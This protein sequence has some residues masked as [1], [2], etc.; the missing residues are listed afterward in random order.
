MKKIYALLFI[1]LVTVGAIAQSWSVP[2]DNVGLITKVTATWC[3]P[4]GGWG[5]DAFGELSNEY[6]GDHILVALYASSS[7]G[8]Y[9]EGC[10][11]MADEIG[12][13]GYPNFA[14]NGV[15]V[16]TAAAS[17]NPIV[18]T[19]KTDAPVIANA[20]Y[21]VICITD[22]SI[23]ILVKAKFFETVPGAILVNAFVIEDGPIYAQA[24]QTG[25]VEH[26]H[27]H[28]GAFTA[29]DVY[30]STDGAEAGSE[31]EKTMVIARSSSW[32]LDHVEIATTLWVENEVNPSDLLYI[33][34]TFEPQAGEI[35]DGFCNGEGGGEVPSGDPGDWP[36]GLEEVNDINIEIFPNPAKDFV[37]I[38]FSEVTDYTV[39][40]TDL[41][42]KQVYTE[43]F[44]STNR[45]TINVL[46]MPEGVYMIQVKTENQSY[47]DRVVIK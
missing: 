32:D 29:D 45:N 38:K 12:F 34:G 4:C 23:E 37:S 1:S 15:D 36:V 39:S 13:G 28:Q 35:T 10:Q 21:E 26:H 5:W 44:T 33:N 8:F 31:Y 41:L 19:F 18:D 16:G 6:H 30:V 22:D 42:G 3:G 27:V 20:A 46:D 43:S 14:G 2:E 25:D 24:G 9:N 40:M 17:V 11:A 47:F 7:S